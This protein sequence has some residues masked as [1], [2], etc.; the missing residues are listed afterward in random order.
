[1]GLLDS[2]TG[3]TTQSQSSF[4]DPNQSPL[5]NQY[6]GDIQGAYG[7]G[8][9]PQMQQ[10]LQGGLGE[11]T[12]EV[13]EGLLSTV[14]GDYLPG[15]EA[16]NT[17]MEA[18]GRQIQPQLASQFGTAGRFGSGLHKIGLGQGLADAGAGIYS[19]ERGRQESAISG[20]PGI[21][22][23]LS[24]T[25]Y[26][27]PYAGLDAYKQRIGSPTVLSQGSSSS[28]PGLGSLVGFNFGMG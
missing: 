7:Q 2:I 9:D 8:V 27:Q 4:I 21:Y 12:P 24:Q 1:M 15:G 26:G 19:Q 20:A 17:Q 16:F 23:N 13:M 11:L 10:Q 25:A 18:M 6:Y 28:S 3:G 5:L 22:N 14:R